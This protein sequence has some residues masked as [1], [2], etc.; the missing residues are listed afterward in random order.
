MMDRTAWV[1]LLVLTLHAP[2][3]AAAQL[4]GLDL[5]KET[6][7]T[8]LV[9][10]SVLN[11]LIFSL[12]L[13][14]T[15]VS[16]GAALVPEMYLSPV[17]F[18]M[19]L[20]AGLAM[21]VFVLFWG[22]RMLGGKGALR[23][24]LAIL[25]WLQVLRLVFQ[26]CVAFVVFLAPQIGNTLVIAG[27]IVGL[28]ILIGFVDVAHRFDSAGRAFGI[29]FVAVMSAV[30]GLAFIMSLLGGLTNLGLS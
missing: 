26:T 23:D 13:W 22:G 16:Q 24:V 2:K 11:S 28:W 21:T 7:W 19:F 5:S 4:L 8:A 20:A 29:I 18:A 9:L 30:V 1:N 12:S 25:V 15:P 27:N 17:L 14:G 10:F 3:K 6:L